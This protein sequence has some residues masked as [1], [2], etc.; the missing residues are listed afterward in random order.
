MVCVCPRAKQVYDFGAWLVPLAEGKAF[1]QW[2]PV[3]L[4]NSPYA[5]QTRPVRLGFAAKMTKMT[6]MI[7]KW[8]DDTNEAWGCEHC[9]VHATTSSP[10]ALERYGRSHWGLGVVGSGGDPLS[11]H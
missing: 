4:H 10:L 8:D 9:G 2:S 1:G 5:T 3:L 7:N 11:M 6:K